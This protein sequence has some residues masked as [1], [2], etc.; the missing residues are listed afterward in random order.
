MLHSPGG[1][2]IT[3][4]IIVTQ[5][6]AILPVIVLPRTLVLPLGLGFLVLG[7]AAPAA[8]GALRAGGRRR[9]AACG[10]VARPAG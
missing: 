2:G 6:I 1:R 3:I 10:G 4:I 5:C 8:R 9:H 7:V